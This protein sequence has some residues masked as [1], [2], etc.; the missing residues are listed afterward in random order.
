MSITGNHERD[1]ILMKAIQ[2]A[3]EDG[4]PQNLAVISL[5]Y[6][7]S[8]FDLGQDELDAALK[9]QA[10]LDAMLGDAPPAAEIESES[11]EPD[12]APR[13]TED[14][15]RARV[16]N[17]VEALAQA[18]GNVMALTQ[19]QRHARKRLSDSVTAFQVGA[20]ALKTPEQNAREYIAG[21]Q[22]LKA[23][24]AAGEIAEEDRGGGPGPSMIDKLAFGRGGKAGTRRDSWRRGAYPAS[25]KGAFVGRP[26]V[27]S[28]R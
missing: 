1:M 19:T 12:T 26:K 28:E 23:M 18:R 3:R 15:A 16:R 17:L 20:G 8:D 11:T 6:V 7:P 10:R 5:E 21:E 2:K 4:V 13:L 14:E 24:R 22:K 9:M 25:M 27:P